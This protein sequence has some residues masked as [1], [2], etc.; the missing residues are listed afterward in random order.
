M[1]ADDGPVF[2][3]SS[4]STLEVFG[5]FLESDS[6]HEQLGVRAGVHSQPTGLLCK[7]VPSLQPFSRSGPFCASGQTPGALVAA[8]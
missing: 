5:V 2:E 6:C 4:G 3:L 8:L 1:K 7:A